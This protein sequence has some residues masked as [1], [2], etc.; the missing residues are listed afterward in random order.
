MALLDDADLA[1]LRETQTEVR[2]TEAELF[3]PATRTKDAL[4]GQITTVVADG[5]PLQV[6]ITTVN[7]RSAGHESVL[8]AL[9]DRYGITDLRKVRSDL[10][11]IPVGSL[12][13]DTELGRWYQ[14][15]AA[16]EAQEWTTAALVYVVNTDQ[17][18][19]A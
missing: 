15:V 4:G 19:P 8:S 10:V 9:A 2:P 13:H 17:R 1:Y 5:Q 11:S 12:L 7:T 18:P 6:R 3:V 14:V 16:P